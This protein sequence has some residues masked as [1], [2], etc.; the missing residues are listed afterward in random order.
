[1]KER[2]ARLST[3]APYPK[4]AGTA[5]LQA[6][7]TPANQAKGEIQQL[8]VD[9]ELRA[10]YQDITVYQMEMMLKIDTVVNKYLDAIPDRSSKILFLNAVYNE[11]PL[12]QNLARQQGLEYLSELILIKANM[13]TM[14]MQRNAGQ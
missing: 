6:N 4:T 8:L 13:A 2:A 3:A 5:M 11:E 10:T 12:P 14:M 1:M 7:D 9:E